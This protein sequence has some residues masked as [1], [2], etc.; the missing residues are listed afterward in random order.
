MSKIAN[1]KW[2]K[3]GNSWYMRVIGSDKLG[4]LLSRVQS[5]VISNGTELERLIVERSNLIENIDIFIERATIWNIQNGTFL[6][7]KKVFKK[8]E[9]YSSIVKGIEPDM[10]I[11]IVQNERICKVIELKDGDNFDTK[12]A[13]WEKEHFKIKLKLKGDKCRPYYL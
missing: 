11:F 10:L 8:S 9:K 12:K 6:C 7:L 13:Q 1:A 4:Q 5:T 3:D 2:R